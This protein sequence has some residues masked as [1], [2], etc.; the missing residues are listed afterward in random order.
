MKIRC[1]LELMLHINLYEFVLTDS[2]PGTV[3]FNLIDSDEDPD[4]YA[5]LSPDPTRRGGLYI[6][7]SRWT[8]IGMPPPPPPPP[9]RL[10]SSPTG[11]VLPSHRR[12]C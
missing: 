12:C 1:I 11:L 2:V 8:G 5:L 6:A 4:G 10:P 3:V 7:P 9:M